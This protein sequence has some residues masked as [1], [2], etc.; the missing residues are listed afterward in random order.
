MTNDPR[1][2]PRDVTLEG[3]TL[4]LRWGDGHESRLPLA[5]LRSNCPCARCRTERAS[6]PL[7][8]LSAP[9]DGPLRALEIVPVGHYALRILWSDEHRSG[10]YPF[11]LLRSLCACDECRGRPARAPEPDP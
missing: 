8:V 5:L 9:G 4:R 11:A 6:G 10:I 1:A 7:G 2:T 3:D